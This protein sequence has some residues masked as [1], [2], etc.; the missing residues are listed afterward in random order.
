MRTV[1]CPGCGKPLPAF[2]GYC[3]HCEETA[4]STEVTLGLSRASMDKIFPSTSSSALAREEVAGV[5]GSEASELFEAD[6]TIELTQRIRKVKRK[7]IPGPGRTEPISAAEPP[8][9]ETGGYQGDNLLVADDET[10]GDEQDEVMSERH[11]TWQKVVEHK[12]SPTL[13]VPTLSSLT[14]EKRHLW[15]WQ[16]PLW[17]SSRAFFW[18]NVLALCVLLLAGG[19]G[20]AL[21]VARGVQHPGAAAELH[22]SP[23]TIALGGILTLRGFHFTPGVGIRLSRDRHLTVI[24]TGGV[25]SVRADA[26]GL[27]NDTVVI[28]PMWLS[29]SHTLYALDTHTQQLASFTIEVVGKDALQGPP[30]LLL[31]TSVLD[32]AAGDEAT[33]NSKL[34]ALS[35]AGGGKVSWQARGSQQWVQ[36]TPNRGSILSGSHQSV[37]VAVDRSGLAPGSYRTNILFISN[38]EQVSLTVMMQ[39]TSLQP[40][41]EAVLQLAPAVLTFSGSAQGPDPL[42]QTITVSNPGI[43]PLT[44]GANVSLQ[45]G[46]GWLRMTPQTGSIAPGGQEQITVE[47][48]TLNLSPNVY[49][50]TLLFVNQGAQPVQGSPQS[51]YVSLTVTPTCTLAVT[52]DGLSFTSV[53]NRPSPSDQTLQVRI[54]SGCAANQNWTVTVNTASGGSWLHLTTTTVTNP[55]VVGVGVKTT[56]LK[57]GRY[58]GTLTFMVGADAQVVPVTLT[59]SP[60]PCTISGT[61]TLAFQGTASQTSLLSQI[62][63]VS[64]SACSHTLNW[65]SAVSGGSWLSATPAGTLISPGIA[66]V[67]VQANLAALSAGSY[68]GTVIITVVDSVSG[69]TVGIVRVVV[70]LTAIPSCS[71]QVPSSTTLP[72]TA[73]P[74]SNPTSP[75]A[76]FTVEVTGNCKGNVTVTPALSSDSSNWLAISGPASIASGNAATFTVTVTSSS[77]A[78]GS[79]TGTITLTATDSNGVIAGSPQTASVTLTVQ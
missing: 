16:R 56:D 55:A 28:D 54:A 71:L 1:D 18:L 35:N 2:A 45:N 77:L 8:R 24:D 23:S 69:A 65:T 5:N 64:S 47:V 15:P 33:N 22:A 51:I 37:I 11:A 76:S 52:P 31:S 3:P 27:F 21:S 74:G 39:V 75:T 41:H 19:F 60:V 32:L 79:Y 38:T 6:Q 53:Q 73:S 29:G 30:H 25:S 70:T 63:T 49:T 68:T 17:C 14:R 12:T 57:P 72:F 50:A 20:V 10:L 61:T 42:A 67:S 7:L 48:T 9:P 78:A 40:E 43:R 4:S 26:H 34:L 66:S 36:I 62:A 13:P 44:W 59:V 58:S 46:F